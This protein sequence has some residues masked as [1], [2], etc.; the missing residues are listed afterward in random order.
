MVLKDLLKEPPESLLFEGLHTRIYISYL[1]QLN[2]S[3]QLYVDTWQV[4]ARPLF[5]SFLHQYTSNGFQ[6]HLIKYDSPLS[7]EAADIESLGC[8]PH[9]LKIS[10]DNL[11]FDI[12]NQWNDCLNQTAAGKKTLLALDSLSPLLLRW[13]TNELAVAF[14]KLKRTSKCLTFLDRLKQLLSIKP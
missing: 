1:P 4:P 7:T 9:Y 3:L 10:H 12:E 8:K 6:I 13:S 11:L 5:Y 14:R 2:F